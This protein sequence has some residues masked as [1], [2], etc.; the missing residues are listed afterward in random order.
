MA[1]SITDGPTVEFSGRI[2]R[3]LYNRVRARF[4]IMGFNTFFIQRGLEMLM[5]EMDAQ[6]TLEQQV[7]VSILNL[8][9]ERKDLK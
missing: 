6:P 3:E 9:D 7:R 5:D 1:G 4:P 2:P 8:L